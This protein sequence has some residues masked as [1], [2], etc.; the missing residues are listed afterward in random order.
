MVAGGA[1]GAAR[2]VPKSEDD[3]ARLDRFNR[4]M[5]LPIVVSAILPLIVVP[6]S[7]TLAGVLVGVLTWLVFLVD[8]VVHLRLT[9]GYLHTGLGIFDLLVVLLTSPW[10]LLPGASVGGLVNVLRLARL[11][12]LLIATRGVRRLLARLGRVAVVAVLVMV[13]SSAVAYGAEHSTNPGFA[14]FGDALWWGV[15]TL[16]TVGYGDIVPDTSAGRWA[17]VAIMITG[18]SVLGLLAGSLASFF[19]LGD[20]PG[21]PASD[22]RPET[23]APATPEVADLIAEIALLRAQMAR[24][25]ERLDATET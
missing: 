20:Q 16:T 18:I 19:R 5:Q 23:P 2:G 17:G 4:Y 22:P 24:L 14:T 12:R 8:L 9:R 6:Q 15:V 13:V 3:A 21:E 11:A 25:T 7:G 10:Y 1:S